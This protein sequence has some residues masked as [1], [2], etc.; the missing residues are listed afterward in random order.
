M[1]DIYIYIYIYIYIVCIQATEALT[2]LLRLLRYAGGPWPET[3]EI[4]IMEVSGCVPG[5]VSGA[6][7]MGW[8]LRIGGQ[9]KLKWVAPGIK[10][11]RYWSSN[12]PT[13]RNAE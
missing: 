11:P 1:F 4:D 3:G 5:K 6:V 13:D 10:G 12:Q 9:E 2:F 8:A 7:H